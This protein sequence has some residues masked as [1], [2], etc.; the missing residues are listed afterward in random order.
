MVRRAL[1]RRPVFVLAD[2]GLTLKSAAYVENAA[3]ALLCAV[4][5]P[6]A[7]AGRI[8][9]VTDERALTIRQMA[10]I[11]ADELDHRFE[12]VSMPAELAAPARPVVMHHS[13]AHRVVNTGPLQADL[14]YRDLVAPEEGLRRTVRWLVDN[15]PSAST[16]RRLQDP[17]D[18]EAE[19][20]L[21]AAWRETVAGFARPRFDPEPGFGAAY[22]GRSPNP[23]TGT[24]R[25][26]PG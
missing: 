3:H 22:Y 2:G 10:E 5:R 16:E 4:D 25:V 7:G 21:I 13:T 14:G 26:E 24:S 20:R 19:D 17:F 6:D 8:F 1:D 11:V 12:F 15:R 9:N 23:A 18:Y